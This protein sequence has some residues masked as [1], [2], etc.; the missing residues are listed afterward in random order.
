MGQIAKTYIAVFLLVL[1]A[2]IGAGVIVASFN[3]SDAEK[4]NMDCVT[5]IEQHDFSDSIINAC[6][7]K[8]AED[9]YTLN[10][11]KI[12]ANNDGHTDMAECVLHYK[13]A[14]PF[15]NADGVDHFARAYAR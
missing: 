6:K 2:A 11:S 8:A 10:V 15:L 14:I 5:A 3:A 13:Y 4:Y 12:D 9:G 1:F 7:A